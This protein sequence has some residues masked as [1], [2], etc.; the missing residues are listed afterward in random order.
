MKPRVQNSWDRRYFRIDG[1]ILSWYK[2]HTCGKRRDFLALK[3]VSE[4][5]RAPFPKPPKPHHTNCG[6]QI[7]TKDRIFC[8]VSETSDEADEWVAKLTDTLKF[9]RS[10]EWDVGQSLDTN[11]NDDSDEVLVS[12]L[13]YACLTL[14]NVE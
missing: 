14:V 1:T 13:M 12:A 8:L 6:F 3:L 5:Q 9:W 10:R 4:V 11:Q 2:D 7:V